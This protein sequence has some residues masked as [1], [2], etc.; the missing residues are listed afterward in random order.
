MNN[1]TAIASITTKVIQKQ[2]LDG[3]LRDG[4]FMCSVAS[5]SLPKIF[6]GFLDRRLATRKAGRDKP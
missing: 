3:I 5:L 1:Q 4:V 2:I 6:G